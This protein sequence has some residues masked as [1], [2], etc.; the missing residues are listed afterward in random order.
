MGSVS[1]TLTPNSPD[2][3]VYVR[4]IKIQVHQLIA[5][6]YQ[7]ARY[8]IKSDSEEPSITGFIKEA[9]NNRLRADCPRWCNI[10]Y[11]VE[12]Q[13]VQI[14]G[15]TGKRRPRTDIIIGITSHRR[16]E[17]IFEA[18][19]LSKN[20]FGVKKY[21]GVEGIGRFVEGKYASRYSEAAML[22]YIQSDSLSLWQSK[23][24]EAIDNNANELYLISAQ[25]NEIIINDF[26]LEWVSTHDRIILGYPIDIYHILLDCCE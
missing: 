22:G 17:Y 4:A 23:L 20:G 3:E 1:K 13:P 10:Y 9:I 11:V 26:P 2:F 25:H 8:L 6:G 18:K 16:P 5:W 24:K 19:R 7:D 21:I 12:E 14:S 15:L